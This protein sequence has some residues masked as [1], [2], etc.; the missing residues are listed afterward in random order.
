MRTSQK[1]R[2][3]EVL[4][5]SGMFLGGITWGLFFGAIGLAVQVVGVTCSIFGVLLL[6][7]AQKEE[8]R[9]CGH[10]LQHRAVKGH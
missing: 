7:K 4:V 6:I 1:H 5:V 9:N 2:V 3:S 8:R 10:L